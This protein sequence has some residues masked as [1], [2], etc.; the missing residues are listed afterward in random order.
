MEMRSRP[1]MWIGQASSSREREGFDRQLYV[2]R[3]VPALTQKRKKVKASDWEQTKAAE[4]GL[5]DPELIPL[6]GS[7]M[8]WTE[9][10]SILE[11][12]GK[13]VVDSDR[14]RNAM[15][16]LNVLTMA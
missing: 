10:P 2:A 1:C 5:V 11:I 4:G 9:G 6:Y 14:A 15:H 8:A 3:D 13:T 12:R 7:D 16:R